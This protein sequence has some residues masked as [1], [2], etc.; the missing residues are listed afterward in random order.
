MSTAKTAASQ[1][2]SAG[3]NR[4][5]TKRR[6][7]VV[8]SVD[9]ALSLVDLSNRASFVED[10]LFYHTDDRLKIER[11][12]DDPL[13]QFDAEYDAYLLLQQLQRPMDHVAELLRLLQ[14]AMGDHLG[15]LTPTDRKLMRV[16]HRLW[17]GVY[18]ISAES[19]VDVV[20][21]FG[22]GELNGQEIQLLTGAAYR[23]VKI[24]QDFVRRVEAA[25]LAVTK[26]RPLSDMAEVGKRNWYGTWSLVEPPGPFNAPWNEGSR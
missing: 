21:R 16:P 25:R 20:L 19:L 22:A 9:D 7:R 17:P 10:L 26:G 23:I 13:G 18:E 24:A 4:S 12:A 1:A 6:H 15:H 2:R 14:L 3:G 8:C 5:N 11:P